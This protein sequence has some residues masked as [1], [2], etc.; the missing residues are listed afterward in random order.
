[1]ARSRKIP[2]ESSFCVNRR[3]LLIGLLFAALAA[4]FF[5]PVIFGGK[6]LIPFDNLYRFPPWNAFAAQFGI[7]VPQNELASDLVLENYAWKNFI[8]EAF[9]AKEIPLWNPYLFAGVPFLA[10]GQHSALYPFSLLFYVLPLDRAYGIFVALQLAIAACAM[11]AFTRVLGISRVA[12]IISALAYAFSGFMTVSV[13]FPMVI[14]AA[15]WLPAILAC[16]ELII[17]TRNTYRQI[18]CALVGAIL[19]GIQFLAGHAEISIYILI[20]TAFYSAWRGV[21]FRYGTRTSADERGE[22]TSVREAI[23]VNPHPIQISWRAWI[24]IA[25]MAIL[26]ITL[27]AIQLIPLYELVQNNFRSGSVSFQDVIGW[28][29]P[30]RQIVT[31]FIPDFYGNPTHHAYLDVFDFTTRAAPNETIFWG[32]KNYVEAG[33]YVGILPLLLAIIAI[34]ASLKSHVSSRKEQSGN[35]QPSTCGLHPVAPF[36]TLTILSLLFTFGTPLYAILFFGV[37][38]FNQLHSPFRW[39]FPYTLSI[40]VLAGIGADVIAKVEKP[41]FLK[42]T[43]FWVATF[44]ALI[45]IAL[46]AS[47]FLRDQTLAFAERLVRSS[48]SLQIAFDTGRM[49]YSYEFRNIF[50][51]AI[52]VIFAGIAL[53]VLQSSRWRWLAIAILAA[54]L[55]IIGMQFYPAADPR[56]AD[57]VPP[58]IQFLREDK[59]LYR[60]TTYNNRDEKTFNAN[61]GMFYDLSDI[62]GYDS[63]IPKQYADLMDLLAPQDEL[64]YNRI[65]PFYNPEP[66]DSPLVTIKRFRFIATTASCP[67]HSW[68]RK[69]A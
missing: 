25:V 16:V 51:F 61:I 38:G 6:T 65:A 55:F 50:L 32:I 1:M 22:K 58:A 69:R 18:F 11:Y 59:S 57:F 54:D 47:W 40:A 48:N 20:I 17:T 5:A 27:G 62:R 3:D 8:V 15:A 31:F 66:F 26:G 36:T 33:S 29:Y 23:R 2:P 43:G 56:L 44:G 42:K 30:I 19:L 45:S 35:T 24:V 9:R 64:L 53:R 41:V 7:A 34:V 68:F 46:A 28:A 4:I 67:A 63:I 60:I 14:S 21:S 52:F 12:A 13:T 37:P 49:F 39:V 10:A